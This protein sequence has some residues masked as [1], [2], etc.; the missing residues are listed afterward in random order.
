MRWISISLIW[1]TRNQNFRNISKHSPFQLHLFIPP[2]DEVHLRATASELLV[3]DGD[4]HSQPLKLLAMGIS[5]SHI[6][7]LLPMVHFRGLAVASAYCVV[8]FQNFC[9]CKEISAGKMHIYH[10]GTAQLGVRKQYYCTLH[11]FE[12]RYVYS[13]RQSILSWNQKRVVVLRNCVKWSIAA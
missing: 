3:M 12:I 1:H 5:C 11:S 4:T 2:S 8:R 7:T 10:L 6:F 13:S 9:C